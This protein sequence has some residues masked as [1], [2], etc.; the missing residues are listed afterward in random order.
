MLL[1]YSGIIRL[2]VCRVSNSC[3]CQPE[4]VLKIVLADIVDLFFPV[5]YVALLCCRSESAVVVL[6]GLKGLVEMVA[7]GDQVHMSHHLLHTL[8]THLAPATPP[9]TK[10]FIIGTM[11]LPSEASLDEPSALGL[12]DYFNQREYVAL[13]KTED[14]QTFIAARNIHRY[15]VLLLLLLC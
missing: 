11:T 7:V 14:I 5:R 3:P 15:V 8:T 2:V 1:E 10:L 12:P 9:N 13:M 4:V 6:D